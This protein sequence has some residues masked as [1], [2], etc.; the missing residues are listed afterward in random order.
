MPPLLSGHIMWVV[1]A[2]IKKKNESRVT[3]L[4]WVESTSDHHVNS[5]CKL[6]VTREAFTYLYDFFSF[7]FKPQNIGFTDNHTELIKWPF[8]L[9][10][11]TGDP[12]C[13]TYI[14]GLQNRISFGAI[15]RDVHSGN[16]WYV[17]ITSIV[18]FRHI[19]V[20]FAFSLSYARMTSWHGNIFRIAGHLWGKV[21]ATDVFPSL[22]A[23]NAELSYFLLCQTKCRTVEQT[24]MWRHS[25]EH[26]Q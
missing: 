13:V 4:L 2:N 23:S 22:R 7:S 6:P 20:I 15:L 3:G 8:R 1:R 11:R 17:K 9:Q 26:Q 16:I 18:Y 21:Q 14:S 12:S 25:N 10:N 24:L 19:L 5:S